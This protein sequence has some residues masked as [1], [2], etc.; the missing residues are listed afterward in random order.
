MKTT[1]L[2][3]ITTAFTMS[4]ALL[5]GSAF[6]LPSAINAPGVYRLT[7]PSAQFTFDDA[8]P[9]IVARF[10]PGQRF[11]LQA[12]INPEA[13]KTITSVVFKVDS[14][15]VSGAVT[16]LT[17]DTLGLLAN[18][19]SPVLRAYSNATPGIHTFT[20]EA[21]QNDLTVL[22]D[23]GNF[24]VMAI[25]TNAGTKAKNIIFCIGDGMGIGH[26]TAA[27]IMG[28]G[29]Q[30]GKA[31]GDLVTDTFPNT[32]IVKT[33]SLNS[34]VTDSAPGAA[35]YSTGNKSNNNQEGVF[36]DDTVAKFD[37]PRVEYI[38][39]YLFRTQGKALGIV[40]TSDVFDATPAAFAVHT[41]DRGAGTGICD[42]FLDEATA[43][44]GLKVLMGGG[45][46]WFLPSTEIGSARSVASDY[47]H[48][49]ELSTGWGVATG[50]A[51]DL[52]RN[53]LGDFQSAGFTYAPDNTSL[54]AVPDTT[55]KLLGLFAFSNMNVALD[56]INNRRGAPAPQGSITGNSVVSDY[57]F[58]DQPLLNEMTDKAL[59]V[60]S[61]S[62]QGFVLMVEGSSIDKQ[63]HNMDTERWILDTMEFDNAIGV[64][65]TFAQANPNTLVIVT[66]DHECAGIAINGASTRTNAAQVAAAAAPTTAA[67]AQ[68]S[69]ALY[70][71]A[72]FPNYSIAADGFPV[73]TDIDYRMIVGYAANVDRK[74]DFLTNPY[75][76]RDSQQ[77]ATN[78]PYGVN[79]GVLPAAPMNRD[80]NGYT[81]T[82]QVAGTTAAHTAADVPVY[83]FGRG[84][85]L[86]SGTMD[87]TDV[88]FKAMQAA[89]GGSK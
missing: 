61:N 70:E 71:A 37:N 25:N 18:A 56:K 82:G 39:E 12:T 64:C 65:K 38:G 54:A 41:Q 76:L 78:T 59:K 13:G 67:V 69:V 88:F 73:T 77:P 85:V 21:T 75:P 50:N 63:A 40:T 20:V 35:C 26:R 42:Q 34:I 36:P 72:G 55:Q 48:A 79:L 47:A 1:R 24:E 68:A 74:E 53:L 7:P 87:N 27:R 33:A 83:S 51:T 44:A 10:L 11:D 19:V 45:R 62:P 17:P 3:L 4:A 80:A 58:P 6:A 31:L 60:L 43:K 81:I 46:K 22:S 15:P 5:T 66:A 2:D 9:P 8:T 29:V 57:G 52:N 89:I 84:S 30:Q 49:A 16:L 32:G 14:A 28:K 86:Y 23:S